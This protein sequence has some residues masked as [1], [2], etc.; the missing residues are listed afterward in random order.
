[1]Y[2]LIIYDEDVIEQIVDVIKNTIKK[3]KEQKLHF[4]VY[5][6]SNGQYPYTEEFEEVMEHITLC[7]LPDAI[8]KAYQN[9][10]PKRQR[11]AIPELEEQT[12]EEVEAALEDEIIKDL[13]NQWPHHRRSRADRSPGCAR[14]P[15]RCA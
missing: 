15:S 3:D 1:M 6:F 4:K 2:L 11:K 9:V 8:Y 10:L 5:V 13:F 12:T 14:S 7:A